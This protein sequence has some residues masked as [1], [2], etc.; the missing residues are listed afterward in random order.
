MG[1][2]PS[3]EERRREPVGPADIVALEPFDERMARA[4]PFVSQ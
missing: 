1:W 3:S 4:P 2:T